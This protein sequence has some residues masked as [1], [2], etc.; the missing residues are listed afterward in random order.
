MK[1]RSGWLVALAVWAAMGGTVFAAAPKELRIPLV[2]GPVAVDGRMDEALWAELPVFTGLT[3]LGEPD[4][5]AEV[6]T[7]FRLAHDNANLYVFAK[8]FEPQMDSLRARWTERDGR[9]WTDDNITI[10]VAAT[11]GRENYVT[12]I[13]NSLGV[14]YD[15]LHLQG[16]IVSVTEYDTAFE[17]AASLGEGS[18]TVEAKIPFADLGLD[19]SSRGPWGVNLG[20]QRYAAGVRESSS[21]APMTSYGFH[22]PRL[23]LPA[24]LEGLDVSPYLWNISLPAQGRIAPDDEGLRYASTAHLWNATG[25]RRVFDI[26]AELRQGEVSLARRQ[27]RTFLDAGQFRQFDVD[28]PAPTAGEAELRVSVLDAQGRTLAWER[29]PVNLAWSPSQIDVRVP[30][31]KN[32]IFATEDVEELVADVKVNLPEAGLAEATLTARLLDGEGR[33]LGERVFQPAAAVQ[34][35]RFPAGDM[36]VGEYALTAQVSGVPGAEAAARERIRKLPPAPGSEVRLAEDLTPLVNGEPFLPFGFWGGHVVENQIGA[37]TTAVH[38]AHPHSDIVSRL[39]RCHELGLMAIIVPYPRSAVSP[40]GGEPKTY[41]LKEEEAEEIREHIRNVRGHPA[42]LGYYPCDEPEVSRTAVEWLEGVYRILDE[43]DPYH[44]VI[45]TNNTMAGIRRYPATADI[46]MPDQYPN[47]LEGGHAAQPIE[48]ITMY[49]EECWEAGG[50][51]KGIWIVPHWFN[52]GLF[53]R[54]GSRAPNLEE[55]RNMFWQAVIAGA[56]GFFGYRATYTGNY[57]GLKYG[58]PYLSEEAQV[59]RGAILANNREGAA[60]LVSGDAPLLKHGVRTAGD[61]HY[62][63]VVNCATEAARFEFQLA[64]DLAGA[65][66]HVFAEGRPAPV[67]GSRLADELGAYGTRIYTTDREAAEAVSLT[68]VRAK[69]AA[70]DEALVRPGNLAH[71]S[72]GVRVRASSSRTQAYAE[73]VADGSVNMNPGAVGWYPTDPEAGEHWVEIAF[74][75]EEAVAKV[76]VHSRGLEA[77][78]LLG[79]GAGEEGWRTLRRAE[80]D[81]G[82]VTTAEF[83]PARIAKL[84]MRA[85]IR[86]RRAGR[87]RGPFRVFEIQA[88]GPAG[89]GR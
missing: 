67:R 83:A 23:F 86:D 39:D 87:Y 75:R 32:A 8:A 61:H 38:L 68:E 30:F 27:W 43:E 14:F 11:A 48:T 70:F 18:W 25:R 9:V 79:Q 59:L 65:S 89:E 5:L 40:H 26:L 2:A 51:R 37:K 81:E 73:T 52:Y 33:A 84:R 88:Y 50:G 1:T 4:K 24:T 76:V 7:E 74:P 47:F 22:F 28:L 63:F 72:R 77:F 21:L 57:S 16:G 42:L 31:Y 62:L 49:M 10:T 82:G 54:A 66:W 6:Q 53:D 29:T 80:A 20:R 46:L 13:V 58:I 56:K 15:G 41:P 55:V 44:P 45:L 12:F 64:P 36:E 17:A 71:I 19:E 3:V 34:E 35:V 85:A 60:R 78:D 69:A